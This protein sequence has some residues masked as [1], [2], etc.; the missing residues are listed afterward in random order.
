MRF[1]SKKLCL[2]SPRVTVTR[3]DISGART[4]AVGIIKVS[5]NE[6]TCVS[7]GVFAVSIT[8]F[9]RLYG[10]FLVFSQYSRIAGIP[11]AYRLPFLST[12][13]VQVIRPPVTSLLAAWMICGYEP[14]RIV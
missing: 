1:G 7:R 2:L 14:V 6:G 9:L 3:E 12:N 8:P 4:K 10:L 13:S 11:S 5:A